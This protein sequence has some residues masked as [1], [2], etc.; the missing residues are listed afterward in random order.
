MHMVYTAQRAR[1]MSETYADFIRTEERVYREIRKACEDGLFEVDV[2]TDDAER[3]EKGLKE[4]GFTLLKN[5][6]LSTTISW[7]G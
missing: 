2:R 6:I 3:V 4:R 5:S 7:Y 1:V